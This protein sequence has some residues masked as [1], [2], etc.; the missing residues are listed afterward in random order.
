MCAGIDV[1]IEGAIH[2]VD[3]RRWERNLLELEGWVDEAL[4]EERTEAADGEDTV[5]GEG[6]V[7]GIWEVLW[8]PGGRSTPEEGEGGASDKIKTAMEGMEVGGDDIDEKE[9]EEAEKQDTEA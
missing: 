2:A 6:A 3:Q 4:E 5:G 9:A 7:E 1:G 8:P